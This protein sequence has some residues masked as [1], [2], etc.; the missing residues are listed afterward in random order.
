MKKKLPLGFKFVI[1]WVLFSSFLSSCTKK[2]ESTPIV[3]PPGTTVAYSTKDFI[4]FSQEF[5]LVELSKYNQ[6]DKVFDIIQDISPKINLEAD[7][8]IEYIL[9]KE[10]NTAGAFII[11]VNLFRQ[12]F[13]FQSFVLPGEIAKPSL[14]ST[15][16]VDLLTNYKERDILDYREDTIKQI[17]EYAAQ[18]IE[19][20][21]KNYPELAV[22]SLSSVYKFYRNGLGSDLDFLELL[23]DLDINFTY[24]NLGV[25]TAAPYPF[26][27]KNSFPMMDLSNMTAN[28]N[29]VQATEKME[30]IIKGQAVD[31]DGDVVFYKWTLE[32]NPHATKIQMEFRWTPDYDGYRIEPYIASLVV[33]DGGIG[34]KTDWRVQVANL[35]RIPKAVSNCPK[36]LREG[37]KVTCRV[38]A[39]D[40]D[41]E[42]MSFRLNDTGVNARATMN[43]QQTNDTTRLMTI[44]NVDAVDFE[45]TPNN[46]D[47][48]SRSAYFQVEVIDASG[49]ISFAPLIFS[50]E[51]INSPPDM[52]GTYQQIVNN[53][54]HE[55]DF[56]ARENPDDG[57]QQPFSFYVQ[58]SDPDNATASVEYGFDILSTPVITGTLACAGAGC[59]TP[60]TCPNNLVSTP[61]N[62]YFCFRWKPS[63][64]KKTGT[65]AFTFKDNHG[66]SSPLRQITLTAQDRNQKPC[67]RDIPE[68]AGVRLSLMRPLTDYNMKADDLDGTSPFISLTSAQGVSSSDV[69]PFLYDSDNNRV[70]LFRRKMAGNTL[71]RAFYRTQLNDMDA[72]GGSKS[73]LRVHYESAYSGVVRFMRP[74]R[75]TSDITIPADYQIETNP[76]LLPNYR[77]KYKTA[78]AA[79]MEKDDIEIWVPVTIY[80][81]NVTASVINSIKPQSLNGTAVSTAGLT[82]SNAAAMNET[83]TVTITR[84]STASTLILPKLMEFFSSN[85]ANPGVSSVHYYNYAPI[86][87][88]VGQASVTVNVTRLKNHI[89]QATAGANSM[90]AI[91]TFVP[92]IDYNVNS[93]LA[94]PQ[95]MM[96]ASSALADATIQV[97]YENLY[98]YTN[99]SLNPINGSASRVLTATAEDTYQLAAGGILTDQSNGR[100]FTSSAAVKLFNTVTLTR[101]T[102]PAE[103]ATAWTL[104]AVG[105]DLRSING[106]RFVVANNVTFAPGVSTATAT[107]ERAN[108][109]NP[110][111]DSNGNPVGTISFE[112]TDTNFKPTFI[113]PV[114][115]MNLILNEGQN[116][117]DFLLE[118]NDNPNNP[119]VPNDPFDRHSYNIAV[120]GFTP[121]GGMRQCR[122][123]GTSLVN[124]DIP[125]TCTP[126]STIL[127]DDYW[128]SARCYIRFFPDSTQSATS[129]IDQNYTYVV[130][131]NDNGILTNGEPHT[132]QQVLTVKVN[133]TNDAPR[134]TDKD[135]NNITTAENSPSTCAAASCG[136][137]VEGNYLEFPVFATDPDRNA[138]NKSL[139]F[140]L[141][142]QVYDL[143]T[144]QWIARPSTMT[145]ATDA[146]I[147][148]SVNPGNWG[149]RFKGRV[150]WLPTD[151]EAKRL[152]GAGFIVK[153]KVSDRGSNPSTP[154]SA[155][156][157]YK[158]TVKNVNNPPSLKFAVNALV[159]TDLHYSSSSAVTLVD[160]DY[161]SI[162]GFSPF[163]GICKSNDDTV[164]SCRA[165]LDGW[166]DDITSYDNAYVRNAGVPACRNGANVEQDLALPYFN[167]QSSSINNANLT[168]ES[169]YRMSW[170]AQRRHIGLHNAYLMVNDNGDKDRTTAPAL[171]RQKLVMPMILN[172]VAPVFFKSPLNVNGVTTNFPTQAF[173]NRAFNY[174][175]LIL[176][177][178][179][180]AVTYTL[181]QAPAGMRLDN[182]ATS[183]VDGGSGTGVG[184]T[185][186][187]TL[188]QY[189][190]TSIPNSTYNVQIKVHD[191]VTGELDIVMF[192]IRVKSPSAPVQAAPTIVSKLPNATTATISENV[193]NTFSVF[194]N[195]TNLDPLTYSWFVDNVKTFD[196]NKNSDGSGNSSS[197][198][199]YKPTINDFG[200]HVIKVE[201]TDGFYTVSYT[202]NVKVLNTVPNILNASA[203]D[204]NIFTYNSSQLAKTV[205]DMKWATEVKVET[206]F[207]NE[208]YNSILFSGSY[209]K[210]GIYNNFVYNLKLKNSN[211]SPALSA[212]AS[213]NPVLAESLPWNSNFETKRL[214]F[215]VD[216][217]ITFRIIATPLPDRNASFSS[218]TTNAVCLPQTLSLSSSNFNPS[219]LCSNS[220]DAA[221]L[222]KN[223]NSYGNLPTA[224]FENNGSKYDITIS[225]DYMK[226]SWTNVGSPNDFH[227]ATLTTIVGHAMDVPQPTSNGLRFSGLGV[228]SKYNRIYATVRDVANKINQLLIFDATPILSN[229]SPTLITT[230]NIADGVNP[231]NQASDIL[232]VNDGAVDKVFILLPG[233]G[234]LAVLPDSN[235]IPV[236]GD[237]QYIANTGQIG[238]SNTDGVN[239]GRKLT[240]NSGS[241]LAYG[242]SKGS[243][244]IFSINPVTNNVNVQPITVMG[245]LDAILTFSNDGSTFGVSRTLGQIFRI[246]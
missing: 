165:P 138:N 179:K 72:T 157:F 54:D 33:T 235:G 153:V 76:A 77:F 99:I 187:P 46:L 128:E 188:A 246:Q 103:L 117:N 189:N 160:K 71:G 119:G 14:A 217:G 16:T 84:G 87:F 93:A 226:L 106:S 229:N 104:N 65:L 162:N 108:H 59:A 48:F 239:Q 154:L 109:T 7:Q 150:G 44:P 32:G 4:P 149:S 41:G 66:G 222:Y 223:E 21:S 176:N 88:A 142:A 115:A 114:G 199:D 64:N 207:N 113:S 159:T 94:T 51:D 9:P 183:K 25:V 107:I 27:I 213:G 23:T 242:L 182:G 224:L 178:R 58:A 238:S 146:A 192:R 11:S 61:Q 137:F 131:V 75:Y 57:S 6:T 228:S 130:T 195:D 52:V 116:I 38:T 148:T 201:L 135:W 170:C 102:T 24:N 132:N 174:R 83:G 97:S 2:D 100:T 139:A 67:V 82:I 26:G 227:D 133:E 175:A 49:G 120:Q 141:E 127:P 161:F 37:V 18:Y 169:V 210:A 42:T 126:C 219:H 240:Y 198:F 214:S 10:K 200:N 47:A 196:E 17:E 158:V 209:M 78:M 70:P 36:E 180:N 121:T 166:P 43:G 81:Q 197:N 243:N 145:I 3:L 13:T 164:N 89:Y 1:L 211:L 35:N 56:C 220:S 233:T 129:D 96:I 230:L 85:E 101:Q 190:A 208:T 73:S 203:P 69:Y 68:S 184:I 34:Q 143:E 39:E 167:L 31:P 74:T 212:G 186:T 98:N 15:L 62:Q 55:W 91:T 12:S 40:F 28:I 95:S 185:W 237:L 225:K 110:V 8:Q 50:V 202:W 193:S 155:F 134:F 60:I 194:A 63:E 140:S 151:A 122:E 245:G 5:Y 118:V 53:T 136:D 20:K 30:T 177:T 22:L 204:F 171:A 105:T 215:K 92:F 236:Q 216:T 168:V 152:A 205:T 234:G 231:D 86:E 125:A 147:S 45:F 191:N 111:V 206:V 173:V 163:L 144:S 232:V 79:V 29:P 112:M 19:N 244:Q 80:D 221:Q 218:S 124:I 90:A 156:A 181:M 172:V 123:K 241:K